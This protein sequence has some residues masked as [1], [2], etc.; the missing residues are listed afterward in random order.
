MPTLAFSLFLL[1]HIQNK[2][3]LG[4]LFSPPFAVEPFSLCLLLHSKS[5]VEPPIGLCFEK[6][7]FPIPSSLR[8]LLATGPLP[9]QLQGGRGP[10]LGPTM[11]ATS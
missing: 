3:T 5:C 7:L 11:Q 1:I 4:I 9:P 6:W 8:R 2:R 10:T